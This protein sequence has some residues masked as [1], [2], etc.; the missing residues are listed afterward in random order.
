MVSETFYRKYR[1][2]SLNELDSIEA[3]EGLI[4]LA[5][6][7][8]TPHALLFAGPRGVGKTSAARILAKT[9]NCL[10]KKAR[11]AGQ[12]YEPCNR[13]EICKSIT[14]GTALDLIEI[15]AASNRGI[16]DIRA[17][18]EKIKLAPVKCQYKVYIV[19]EVHMLTAEAFNAL[20]KTLEEPPAHAIFIL[21]TTA[22]EKLPDTIISRCLR[23]NFRKGRQVEVVAC[24]KRAVKREKL[25]V[26]KG[27]LVEIAKGVDGIF[28]D[29]HKFLEQLS[30]SGK[31]ITLEETKRFLQQTEEL[32]PQ[33]LLELLAAKDV[34][35]S[36]LEIDRIVTFG[37]DLVVF[38]QQILNSLRLGMLAKIG[39][40]DF[41][42]P[43]EIQS[44]SFDQIKLLINLFSQAHRELKFSPIPQL[45]LELAVVEFCGPKKA[46]EPQKKINSSLNKRDNQ[47]NG[48][49]AE[50][51]SRWQDIL[52]EVKPLNHSVQALLRACQPINFDGKT[53]TL[54]V[55]YKFHK[56]RLEEAKS[57]QIVETVTSQ[58]LGM[59]VHLACVL[60]EKEKKED[61]IDLAESILNGKI[62][63]E[64]GN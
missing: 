31:K 40:A 52:T 45:P 24:L 43:K 15:D 3:R 14:D 18:R 10:K 54:K 63:K 62:G 51:E 12:D 47:D 39:L 8:K 2:Q 30:L 46:A 35:K 56:E 1:P 22:P 17:L 5:K 42:E 32:K 53:L 19:D 26:E 7:G 23:F 25:E 49:L 13:C 36:L 61:I 4:N 9:L 27:V 37:G 41:E 28:R 38:V 57:R 50:V 44:L 21:C 60:G 16:D 55:F 58:V 64:G 48:E 59:P 33:K 11:L 6:S 29:A 20:L 34:K